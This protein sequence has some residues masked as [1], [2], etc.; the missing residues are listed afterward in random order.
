MV[1][2]TTREWILTACVRLESP[3]VG[4]V[5]PYWW[6]RK[7]VE[8]DN[9]SASTP[10]SHA[11]RRKETWRVES[12]IEL[13]GQQEALSLNQTQSLDRFLMADG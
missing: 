11:A 10:T 3:T 6:M 2:Y 8:I 5:A 12:F 4:R 1:R 9:T 7:T 13:S